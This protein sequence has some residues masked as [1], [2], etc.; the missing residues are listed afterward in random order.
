MRILIIGAGRTGR[1]LAGQFLK[2]EHDVVVVDPAEDALATLDGTLDVL[3]IRGDGTDPGVLE[4]A[5]V[6]RT[7]LVVAVADHDATNLL[8]CIFARARGVKRTVAR[9]S[10]H[11]YS[12]SR[13]LN[14]PALGVDLLVNQY[15]EYAED[16]Y[17]TLR[18]PGAIEVADLLDDNI[19]AV[20][21]AIHMDSPLLGTTLGNFSEKKWLEKIRFISVRRGEASVTPRGDTG[22]LV[23]D[24]VYFIGRPEDV[25]GFM[26]WAWPEQQRFQKIAIA[27]GGE[28]GL[29]LAKRLELKSKMQVV[30]IEKEEAR[31]NYCSEQLSRALVLH[32]DA[33][34]QD[35][36]R[37]IGGNERFVYVAT[38]GS[39]EHNIIGCLVAEKSGARFTAAR[40]A[41]AE[42]IEIINQH[43]LLDRVVDPRLAMTNAILHF[44]RGRNVKAAALMTRLPGELLEV[45]LQKGHEWTEKCI[46]DLRLPPGITMVAVQRRKTVLI[47]T[48]TVKLK[49]D[50]LLVIYAIP[51]ALDALD[52]IL[53][54]HS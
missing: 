43:S 26:Q 36:L 39:D 40:I 51:A 1:Y 19:M 38:T 22:F 12:K 5:G 34:D 30:L 42:Y 50:D 46:Q 15:D 37:E 29:R 24:E 47:A 33:L 16:L 14:F 23:G 45:T 32:G 2:D 7:D 49:A 18:L 10:T 13:D 8:A 44:V 3:T 27:G 17:N 9:V 28:L 48:G 52:K 31:A 25:I 6:A 20:G 4:Q 35:T 54:T 11:A 53:S 41:S 21:M